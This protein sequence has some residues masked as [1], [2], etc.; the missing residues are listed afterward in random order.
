MEPQFGGGGHMNLAGAQVR[1]KTTGEV[2]VMLK[3]IIEDDREG[4]IL[5]KVILLEDVK[6]S[7][8]KKEV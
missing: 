3:K 1:N 2:I 8:E 5:M 6:I 4:G 7:W